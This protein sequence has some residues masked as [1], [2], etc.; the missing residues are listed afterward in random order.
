MKKCLIIGGGLAGLSAA[1]H[2]INK[3][4]NVTLLEASPKLGGRTYSFYNGK[5][6][7]YVDNGQ[8]IMMGCYSHTLELLKI[9]D[10]LDEIEIQKKLKIPVV[11]KTGKNYYLASQSDLYPVNLISAILN[12]KALSLK[13]RISVLRFYITEVF[14]GAEKSE[15][16]A[17]AEW[18]SKNGQSGNA[19]SSFWEMLSVGTLNSKVDI[20]S[21]KLFREVLRRVFFTGNNSIKIILPKN[22]L[23]ETFSMRAEKYILKHGGKINLSERG[24]EITIA[25]G[26]I[27]EVKSGKEIYRQFDFIVSAVPV[28]SFKKLLFHPQKPEF[29]LPEM[30]YSPIIS[31]HIWLNHNPF[32]ERFYNL[33]G[34]KLDWLFNNGSHITLLK[35]A[36]DELARLDNETVMEICHFEIKKYFPFFNRADIAD[37]IVI[38]EKQ[39]TF[40]PSIESGITRKKIYNPVANL[41]L[42][43]DWVDTKLP[44][45]I[46]GAI[47]SGRMA[48]D[49]VIKSK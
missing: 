1:V 42:A 23:S 34:S 40:I 39:A 38:K 36:A 49:W 13:E 33:S 4:Y 18:L 8:H 12:Y 48:A 32:K 20:S 25:D 41:F 9:I 31:I 28:E 43:G 35:S 14:F 26:K 29:V 46:E 37:S 7:Q 16:N 21:A 5:H 44:A 2:L 45:T 27:I 10:A 6:N 11:D 15:N 30:D 17:V 3:S 19:I 24:E 22:S 47:K